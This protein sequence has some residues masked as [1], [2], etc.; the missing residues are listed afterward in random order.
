MVDRIYNV[1]FL[2][3]GNS[4]RSQMAEC[5]LNRLGRG[6]FRA[7]SAGSHPKEEVH[8]LTLD[9]LRRRNHDVAALRTK[10]WSEFA[11]G[12]APRMDF[13][14]TVCDKAA[15]EVCPVWPGQPMTAHWGFP[16]PAAAEGNEAERKIAFADVYRELSNRLEIF[17]SLPMGQLDRLTLQKRLRDIGAREEEVH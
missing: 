9:L 3:T 8:P 13:V 2:C 1:L 6:R 4:A 12:N 11:A 15:G 10:D 16:D 7:F 5:L 14:I 17:V